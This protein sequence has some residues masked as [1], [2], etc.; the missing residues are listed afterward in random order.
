MSSVCI[1]SNKGKLRR[2]PRTI[3]EKAIKG[4]GIK[5]GEVWTYTTK[6][7]WKQCR[8]KEKALIEKSQRQK[9]TLEA[10]QYQK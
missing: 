1:V 3:A 4:E 7:V 6:K 8:K 2:V 10:L 5:E 9:D